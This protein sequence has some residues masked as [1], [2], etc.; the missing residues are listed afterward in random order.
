MWWGRE[1]YIGDL[2]SDH[3]CDVRTQR[4]S[5]RV[6]RFGQPEECVDYFKDYYGPTINAY[7]NI[8]DDPNE[9]PSS[10]PNSSNSAANTSPTA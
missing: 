6:K 8:S 4:G 7:R 5:L 3:V 1:E 2:F 9:L 10:T